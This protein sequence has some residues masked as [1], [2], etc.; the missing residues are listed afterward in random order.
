MVLMAENAAPATTTTIDSLVELLKKKGKMD[1][2]SVSSALGVDQGVVENWAKVLEKGN[3]V[4]ITYEVGKMFLTL[5]TLSAEQ[6]STE[7]SKIGAQSSALAS[8]SE[9]QMLSLDKLTDVLNSIKSSVATA[10]RAESVEMPEV[11]RAIVELNN[12]YS[13]VEQRNRGLEQLSKRAEQVYDDINKRVSDLSGKISY[14]GGEGEP[15]G[16]GEARQELAGITKEVS[17]VN[18]E[19]SSMGRSASGSMEQIRKGVM[20]QAKAL[21]QQIAQS[22]KE[23][24]AKLQEY[25]KRADQIERQL[26]ERIRSIGST[27][28]ELNDFNKEKEKQLRRLRD[29]RVEVNNYYVKMGEEL[30]MHK[31]TAEEL[32]KDLIDKV[33]KLKAGFGEAAEIDDTLS[34]LKGQMADLEKEISEARQ[35]VSDTVSRL[36]ALNSLASAATEQKMASIISIGEKATSA[37]SKISEIKDR[38][39]MAKA[40]ADKVTRKNKKE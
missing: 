25:S 26:K 2:A 17:G 27:L 31:A 5:S 32:S 20:A 11:R 34:T 37:R 36:R 19:I 23:Q 8:Q 3:I 6:E 14:I 22:E 39:D 16:V 24:D 18:S 13:I 38:V 7:R 29:S 4:K 40:A 28:A 9:S 12:I 33:G 15:K 30:A 1:L 21:E 10:E 35:E